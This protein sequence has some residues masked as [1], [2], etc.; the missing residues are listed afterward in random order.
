MVQLEVKKN[1][2]PI[3]KVVISSDI[4]YSYYLKL[5]DFVFEFI[6]IGTLYLICF[7]HFRY[8]VFFPKFADLKI[9][10]LR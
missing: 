3:K 5:N 6:I 1:N 8:S 9:R 4:S 2:Q 7:Q 10:N